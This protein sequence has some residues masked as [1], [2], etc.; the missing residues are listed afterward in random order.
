VARF[1]GFDH[2]D[3]RVKS[4]AAVESF[5]DALMP[6]LGLPRKRFS[7]VDS[8]GEWH[9]VSSNHRYNT[10][11]YYEQPATGRTPF[12]IGF[13]ERPDHQSGF[14]RIAFRVERE[15]LFDL[16]Q[17]LTKIGARNLEHSEDPEAYPAIFFEDPGGTKL[18]VVSRAPSIA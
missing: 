5:Y 18:E 15:R 6:E 10:I 12:F 9:E 16:E 4:L 8:N 17:L 2:I 7:F 3:C 14:T 13:V 11:E 1:E